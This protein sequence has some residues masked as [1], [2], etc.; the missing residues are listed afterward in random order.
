[1]RPSVHLGRVGFLTFALLLLSSIPA[2]P[3]HPARNQPVTSAAPVACSNSIDNDLVTF[4]PVEPMHSAHYYHTATLL[5][6]GTVLL[7]AGFGFR[8]PTS[9]AELYVPTSRSFTTL[10]GGAGARFEHTATLLPNSTVLIAGGRTYAA[11]GG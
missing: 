9:A 7:V 6:D 2:Y 3:A 10:G 5:D 4:I 8:V 1:M 11:N